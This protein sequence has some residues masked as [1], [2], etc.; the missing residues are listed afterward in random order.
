MPGISVSASAV[1]VI[2]LL[3]DRRPR[4]AFAYLPCWANQR[5]AIADT[6]EDLC[7]FSEPAVVRHIPHAKN[8]L[9]LISS[10]PETETHG[11]R[12]TA[13]I[14]ETPVPIMPQLAE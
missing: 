11:R 1:V 13:R 4:P 12:P 14:A 5:G 8:R 6:N 2:G 9:C 7:S 10:R 3:A